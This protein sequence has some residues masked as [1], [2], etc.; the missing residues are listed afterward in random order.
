MVEIAELAVKIA[1]AGG[2]LK[3]FDILYIRKKSDTVKSIYKHV[4]DTGFVVA[5]LYLVYKGM[6]IA[7]AYI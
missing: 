6:V 2:A 5:A 4:L 1:M 7:G 3:I